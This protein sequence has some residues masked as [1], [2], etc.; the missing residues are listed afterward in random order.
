MC[1]YTSVN[2]HFQDTYFR[3][4]MMKIFQFCNI[5]SCINYIE[6]NNAE[7]VQI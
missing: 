6:I 2:H 5:T 1:L 7:K 3:S 4:G